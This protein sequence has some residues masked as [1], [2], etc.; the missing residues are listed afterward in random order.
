MEFISPSGKQYKANLHS[1]SYLSDG[2]LSPKDMAK[3]YKE[4]G[5]SVLAITDHEAPYEH[6]RLTTEDFLMITGYEAYI[7]PT[8]NC[9]IVPFGPEIHLNLIAKDPNNTTFIGYDP[10]FCKYM[11][12]EL[13]DTRKKAGDFGPRRYE[14]DYIQR[15]IDEANANGYLVSYNHPC[16]S[17]ENF[18][19][20][21]NYDGCYSMEVFN[22]GSMCINGYEYNMA[23]YDQMIRRGKHMFLHGADDN[24]NKK[25]FGDFLCD[26]F[27][28]WTMIMADK[29]DYA[30][31]IDALENGRF[32]ASTG[33]TI[34]A[35]SFE[36]RHVHMEFSPAVRVMMHMSPK[37]T[38]NVYQ[39]DGSE[40]TVAD[41]DIPDSAPY[42]YFTVQ[43]KGGS[44]AHV[45]AFTREE[46]GI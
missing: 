37:R 12:H 39:P 5:Y 34:A 31:I 22:T 2:A 36:G 28:A 35:L 26:S 16:W 43:A 24:H 19:D 45:H 1:H 46:L 21:L 42:V 20:V 38:Q 17:M 30:S 44:L 3:A 25:P 27:G 18:G 41:F 13:A 4:H 29:L 23:L 10:N 14:H 8:P 33:P 6:N 11:P 32:Y 9:E 15:F 7:R 40:F